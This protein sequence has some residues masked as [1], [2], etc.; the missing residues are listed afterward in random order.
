[1]D[2]KDKEN[3]AQDEGT[4]SSGSDLLARLKANIAGLGALASPAGDDDA[5][6][7]DDENGDLSGL[8]DSGPDKSGDDGDDLRPISEYGYTPDLDD[9]EPELD[10]RIPE[11]GG[12]PAQEAA[13]VSPDPA[14]AQ[15]PD[16]GAAPAQTAAA[17]PGAGAPGAGVPGSKIRYRYTVMTREEFEKLRSKKNK[18]GL[19][20]RL[21]GQK[22]GADQKAPAVPPAPYTAQTAQPVQPGPAP[23]NA[24]EIDDADGIK[25]SEDAGASVQTPEQRLEQA[26]ENA[27]AGSGLDRTDEQLMIG[28]GM[29]DELKRQVGEEKA[30]EIDAKLEENVRLSDE[31]V[32]ISDDTRSRFEF[33]S[34][35]QTKS[36][37]AYYRACYRGLIWRIAV[38]ILLLI[39]VFIHENIGVFGG[40]LPRFMDVNT[41]PV[42]HLLVGM[43]YLVL[44]AAL[45]WKPLLRSAKNLI[46]AKPDPVSITAAAIAVSLIYEIVMCFCCRALPAGMNVRSYNLAAVAS[47]L[48]ALFYELMNVQREIYSFN[49]TASK[50]QKFVV[51]RLE[52]TDE[53]TRR[54]NE[55]FADSLG[56]SGEMFCV[57]KVMFVD[58]FFSRVNARPKY[59][60]SLNYLLPAAVLSG[61]IFFIYGLLCPFVRLG[62]AAS[63]M[64]G[65]AA[66]MMVLPT[67]ALFNYSYP[68]FKAGRES[69]DSGSAIVGET[70]LEDYSAGSTISFDDREV[71]P[72]SRV[73]IKHV[74]YFGS[75]AVDKVLYYAAQIF[76]KTGGPLDDALRS[77]TQ[78]YIDSFYYSQDGGITWKTP[79]YT[80]PTDMNSSNVFTATVDSQ[81]F[82]WIICGQSGE[83]WRGRLNRMGWTKE[84]NE[85][86]KVR[87]K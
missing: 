49:V 3:R 85:F 61:L 79:D 59:H 87:R 18:K 36:V 13:V 72:V 27:Q 64:G 75:V 48:L 33:V 24:A 76:A 69:F 66:V 17:A 60:R 20:S 7:E 45:I 51:A 83:I 63:F 52:G 41:Y 53:D 42:V 57:R 4:G 81:N 71:F 73:K 22:N 9:D 21:F 58:G 23:L 30:K 54:E 32:A 2:N 74:Q 47:V 14:A 5:L 34:P 25:P 82:I 35:E 38:C 15:D 80:L 55:L 39:G 44:A 50:K 86:L 46:A 28:L 37:F 29:E 78:D 67:M 1:M 65:Y 8:A 6:D 77:M 10:L 43:Q 68:F 26:A 12:A 31:A 16:V 70:S 62:A 56:G 19:F 84:Q 11:E 40:S